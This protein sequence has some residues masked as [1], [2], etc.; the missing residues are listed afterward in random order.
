MNGKDVSPDG[1]TLIDR[2]TVDNP[3]GDGDPDAI[4]CRTPSVISRGEWVKR[5]SPPVCRL[6]S[7]WADVIK[8]HQMVDLN[9]KIVSRPMGNA[10]FGGLPFGGPAGS[11]NGSGLAPSGQM[12]PGTS[13]IPT[14]G[15]N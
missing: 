8:K 2:P 10:F 9:G 6:N 15:L 3:K 1:K 11:N 14:N 4:T 5:H 13:S 7:F 12:A